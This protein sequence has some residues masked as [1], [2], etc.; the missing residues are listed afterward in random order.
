MTA[1]STAHLTT[2]FIPFFS[3]G[4]LCKVITAFISVST[5]SLIVS[6]YITPLF[7]CQQLYNNV[8]FPIKSWTKIFNNNSQIIKNSS[9]FRHNALKNVHSFVIF[10]QN[11]STFF[12]TFIQLINSFKRT[13]HCAICTIQMHFVC[14]YSLDFFKKIYIIKT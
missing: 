11:N 14:A 13:L 4:A 6:Y 7:F 2:C 1:P 3:Y 5:V 12:D 10:P 8:N 9:F